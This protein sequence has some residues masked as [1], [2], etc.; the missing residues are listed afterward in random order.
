M[1][2]AR[3]DEMDKQEEQKLKEDIKWIKKELKEITSIVVLMY[4]RM[5]GIIK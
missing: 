3:E 4:Q 2:G 5:E 1:N